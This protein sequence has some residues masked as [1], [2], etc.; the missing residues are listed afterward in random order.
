[1]I[2]LEVRSIEDDNIHN[3]AI[4]KNSQVHLYSKNE[5]V[6]QSG[7]SAI[8]NCIDTDTTAEYLESGDI[9]RIIGTILDGIPAGNF[10]VIGKSEY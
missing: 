5:F 8:V 4:S 10:E 6:N 2:K 9:V 7:I 1:M 3:F